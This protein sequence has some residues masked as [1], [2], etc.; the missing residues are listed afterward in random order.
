METKKKEINRIVMFDLIRK[1]TDTT[2]TVFVTASF[3]DYDVIHNTI[4]SIAKITNANYIRS[5]I[6]NTVYFIDCLANSQNVVISE[7]IART[8]FEEVNKGV[9]EIWI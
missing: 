3:K 5:I 8:I 6:G 7:E 9:T 2:F 4:V 1:G